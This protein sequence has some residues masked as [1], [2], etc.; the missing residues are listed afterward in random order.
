MAPPIFFY[1]V[2]NTL[3]N[4]KLTQ[5]YLKHSFFYTLYC[6]PFSISALIEY[7]TS[8]STKCLQDF[9]IWDTFDDDVSSPLTMC[10]N[11]IRSL[12]DPEGTRRW[13]IWFGIG[14]WGC[15]NI[16]IYIYQ[17]LE[18]LERKNQESH[19]VSWIS[20]RGGKTAYCSWRGESI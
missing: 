12:W 2:R 7:G 18:K 17:L 14:D 10:W 9:R 8:P 19:C 11:G 3:C 20:G 5:D 6:F 13:C 16:Y 1:Q 15:N 4:Q